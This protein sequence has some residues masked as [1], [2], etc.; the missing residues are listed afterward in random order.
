MEIVVLSEMMVLI[1]QISWC[2][3]CECHDLHGQKLWKSQVSHAL[4]PLCQKTDWPL[5]SPLSTIESQPPYSYW[6]LGSPTD[7]CNGHTGLIPWI[8]KQPHTN[9]VNGQWPL[10]PGIEQPEHESHHLTQS[11]YEWKELYH[12][13]PCSPSFLEWCVCQGIPLYF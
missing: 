9:L 2:H 3:T 5:A 4:L 1:Y 12:N 7:L 6:L 11:E 13:L 10:P 8:Q